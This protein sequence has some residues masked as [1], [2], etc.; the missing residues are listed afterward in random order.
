MDSPGYRIGI[1]LPYDWV[2][3][4]KDLAHNLTFETGRHISMSS[5]IRAAIRDSIFLNWDTFKKK[6]TSWN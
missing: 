1:R 6:L 5:L 3:V 2:I 4:L